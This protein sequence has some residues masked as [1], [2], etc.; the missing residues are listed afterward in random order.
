MTGPAAV[1]APRSPA[2]VT[3]PARA[4]RAGR[5]ELTAVLLLGLAGA[6]LALLA[7]GR[8]WL[9]V[10]APRRPPLPDVA[11]ALSGRAVE[12]LVP[13]LGVVGLA[14]L[15]ALLA[16]RGRGRLVVGGLLAA[17]GLLLAVRAAGRVTGPDQ[18]AAWSLLTDAGKT[19]GIPPGTAVTVSTMP[20]W[21]VLAVLAGLALLLAGAGALLR[22][23]RWPGMSAR[24][25][26]PTGPPA[27]A[28]TAQAAAPAAVWDAL[29]RGDD[30]TAG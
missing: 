4:A 13:A 15:V 25:D 9:R 20:V 23:R 11:V 6:G 1:P 8:V 7:G 17:S 12:P 10:D 26:A 24:Y 3:G 30:P 16:T 2:E 18:A 19:S 21:P 5:R 22:S 29:D 28:A 14:G 27:P